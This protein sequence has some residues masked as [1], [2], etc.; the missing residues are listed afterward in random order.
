MSSLWPDSF[1][2]QDIKTPYEVLKAQAKE[3]ERLTD[4]YVSGDVSE[5]ENIIKI[6]FDELR[7][8]FSYSFFINSRFVTSYQFRVFSFS[9]EIPFY[10]IFINL[11]SDISAELDCDIRI[12]LENEE[13]LIDFLKRVFNSK[14]IYDIISS[15]M[16]LAKS[17]LNAV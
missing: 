5:T 6:A 7:K 14:K 16:T 9:Y 4:D 13:Q 10:P 11:D 3:L 17:Y 1:K 2:I 12:N 15:L 8:S